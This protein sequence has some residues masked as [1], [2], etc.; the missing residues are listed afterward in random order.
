MKYMKDAILSICMLLSSY[1]YWILM[2]IALLIAFLIAIRYIRAIFSRLILCAKL[3]FLCKQK[4]AT[5][6]VERFLLLS[7]LKNHSSIDFRI[8]SDKIDK[9]YAVKFFPLNPL[10]R[11]VYLNESENAY[12]SRVFMQ[13]Y[14]GRRGALPGGTKF[15]FD[16]A[17][18]KL[19][20]VKLHMPT[21]TDN[22]KNI[23]LLDPTPINVRVAN[24]NGFR[25]TSEVDG[26]RGYT[27][28]DGD[29]LLNHL[30][31]SL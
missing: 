11:I 5:F 25:K 6:K 15:P 28:L 10:R 21:P 4:K 20:K 14:Q 17:E 27:V 30:S 24:G 22:E 12:V 19:K 18:S 7:L 26:C 13:T 3:S 31:R 16:Y 2:A 9:T 23:L 29:E 8:T 1:W